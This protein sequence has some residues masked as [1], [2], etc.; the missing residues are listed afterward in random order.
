MPPDVDAKPFLDAPVTTCFAMD[1]SA[2]VTASPGAA[3]GRVYAGGVLLSGPF[4][5]VT[6]AGAPLELEL[7][8]TNVAQADLEILGNCNGSQ[9]SCTTDGLS[10]TM[11]NLER[12]A[13]VGTHTAS[14]RGTTGARPAVQGTVTVTEFANPF[15]TLPGH[16]TGT[17]SA[18]GTITVSGSFSTAFCPPFLAVTI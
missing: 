17:V 1:G 15:A 14:M 13:E 7:L 16:I 11:A 4:A 6:A 9:P 18:S 3:F 5:P 10:V 8:F 12:D 2:S